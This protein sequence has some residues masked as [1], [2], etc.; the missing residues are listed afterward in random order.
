MM[1]I[2]MQKL[3][4]VKYARSDADVET[5]EKKGFRVV[6]E[7]ILETAGTPGGEEFLP[8]VGDEETIPEQQP[9]KGRKKKDEADGE[10]G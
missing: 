10:P 8:D 4:M 9:K 1:K 5:L 7:S 3:N 2:T 6:E